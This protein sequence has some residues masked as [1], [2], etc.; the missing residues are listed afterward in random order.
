MEDSFELRLDSQPLI[1][2]Y[3][4]NLKVITYELDRPLPIGTH[5]IQVKVRDRAGN[6]TS[7]N[8][9]FKVY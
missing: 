6:E 3:Q 1:Y 2:A 8:I 4:P 7:Q 9:K 5:T